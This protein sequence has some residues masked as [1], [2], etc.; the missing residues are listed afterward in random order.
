MDDVLLVDAA[1]APNGEVMRSPA[2][3]SAIVMLAPDQRELFPRWRKTRFVS[4]LIKPLRRASLAKRVLVVAVAAVAAGG[5]DDRIAGA[6]AAAPGARVLVVEDNPINT[7]LASTLLTRDGC[8]VEHVECGEAAIATVG[9][10]VFDLILIDMRLRGLSGIEAAQQIRETGLSTPIVALTA[11][12]YE[13]DRRA[14]LAAGMDEFLVKPLSPDAL[15]YALKRW[16]GA[17]WT[18]PATRAKV[19]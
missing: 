12:A 11:N 16:I 1:L 10:R 5:E 3:R 13:D 17:S 6:V 8:E 19:G 14:C 15:R 2:G 18:K 7:L 9:V 4:Y